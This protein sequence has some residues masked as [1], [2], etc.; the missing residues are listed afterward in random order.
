MDADTFFTLEQQE[1][2]VAA[3]KEAEKNTSGEIRV[4]VEKKCAYDVRKRAAKV[5][6]KLKMHKTELRNGILFYIATESHTFF[7]AGDKGI[8]EKVGQDFWEKVKDKTIAHFK[9]GKIAE[10]LAEAILE[11]G[12]QLKKHFPY[13][14]A[15]DTNELSDEISFNN[16]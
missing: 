2:I 10:G 11:C 13:N 7:L 12:D 1:K 6:T 14:S 4:H 9:E 8:H 5:F 3:I 16:N 15:T